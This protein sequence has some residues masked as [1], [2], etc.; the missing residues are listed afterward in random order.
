MW[1][2]L[3]LQPPLEKC[4]DAICNGSVMSRD[5][6]ERPQSTNQQD[7]WDEA[8]AFLEEFYESNTVK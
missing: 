8:K 3:V 5:G 6:T 7:T 2:Q 4:T 1:C